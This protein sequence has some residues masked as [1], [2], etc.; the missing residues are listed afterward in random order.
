VCAGGINTDDRAAAARPPSALHTPAGSQHYRL[1]GG[2]LPHTRL[3]GKF[4]CTYAEEN[5]ETT[6]TPV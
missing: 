2:D 6:H 5:Q 4:V 1:H 3:T